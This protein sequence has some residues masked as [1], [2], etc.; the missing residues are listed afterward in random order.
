MYRKSWTFSEIYVDTIRM[1]KIY[2]QHNFSRN[3]FNNLATLKS[4]NIIVGKDGEPGIIYLPFN[5]HF[6]HMVHTNMNIAKTYSISYLKENDI[7]Y[8]NH[9]LSHSISCHDDFNSVKKSIKEENRHITTTKREILNYDVGMH[10][11]KEMCERL[12]LDLG[13]ISEM[14]YIVL[15]TIDSIT[16]NKDESDNYLC[17]NLIFLSNPR[18]G[19]KSKMVKSCK[20]K[21]L[22][23][24]GYEILKRLILSPPD[25]LEGI[26]I[27]ADNPE[28]N[29][30]MLNVKRPG[31]LRQYYG[32]NLYNIDDFLVMRVAY[33]SQVFF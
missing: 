12:L 27:V 24:N 7:R 25:T 30:A 31:V 28:C 16:S 14:R 6:F 10:M 26:S 32:L 19:L 2:V 9:K 23:S 3:F 18:W 17:R 29:L 15:K 5:P 4:L 33:R 1:Q 11:T 22:V 8:E 20:T 13:E 21:T